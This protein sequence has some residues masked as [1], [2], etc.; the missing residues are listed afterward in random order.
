[1]IYN[2]K[3]KTRKKKL[4]LMDMVKISWIE[5]I[6]KNWERLEQIWTGLQPK[7]IISD[8]QYLKN[9]G[10]KIFFLIGMV[11]I[12]WK[13]I[14]EPINKFWERLEKNWT[15]LES[16]FVVDIEFK[17]ICVTCISHTRLH[18]YTNNTYRIHN[19]GYISDT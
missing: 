19:I 16:K 4:F 15:N 2:V 7:F 11:K 5:A 1:M 17:N 9:L 3:K 10:K 8:I 18:R 13:H 6:F 14:N 12:Y